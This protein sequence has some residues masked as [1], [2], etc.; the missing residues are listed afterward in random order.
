MINITPL[1]IWVDIPLLVSTTYQSRAFFKKKNSISAS[2]ID[3]LLVFQRELNIDAS[4]LR[5][6]VYSS[7]EELCS[8][9]TE[10]S[11]KYVHE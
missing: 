9:P 4:S 11:D 7:N 8:F 1:S 6:Y 2:K 10:Y 3:T 5:C